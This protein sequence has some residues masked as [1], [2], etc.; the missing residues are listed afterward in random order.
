MSQLENLLATVKR[1]YEL[2]KIDHEQTIAS[3]EQAAPIAK[4]AKHCIVDVLSAHECVCTQPLQVNAKHNVTCTVHVST[5][6]V[7]YVYVQI[8]VDELPF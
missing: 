6:T 3:N 7:M 2:L 1:D 5:C 8:N 4:L